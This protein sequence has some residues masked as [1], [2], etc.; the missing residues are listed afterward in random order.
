MNFWNQQK[1]IFNRSHV[2][3]IKMLKSIAEVVANHQPKGF[4]NSL[5]WNVGHILTINEQLLFLLPNHPTEF[6]LHYIELFGQ[7]TKP[8][9]FQENVPSLETLID[10]L[11]DQ[12]TR[13][14]ELAV[15]GFDLKLTEP[16]LLEPLSLETNGE[17][18][19]FAIYHQGEHTGFINALKNIVEIA[20]V[21]N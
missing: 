2:T 7:G 21:Q 3:L 14:E 5:H 17:L 1:N 8:T 11:I 12:K 10:Q 15:Q 18:F 9:E 19:N 6:P 20:E 4:N 13:V 16:L